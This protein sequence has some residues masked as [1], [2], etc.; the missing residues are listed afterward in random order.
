M[1]IK[2]KNY[3][4]NL[5]M[6]SNSQKKFKLIILL[7]PKNNKIQNQNLEKLIKIKNK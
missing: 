7:N 6:I 3:P 5:K 1:F 2:L 4:M